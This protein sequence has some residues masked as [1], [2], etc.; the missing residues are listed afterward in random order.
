M[1]AE[2]NCSRCGE[3]KPPS[4]YRSVTGGSGKVYPRT[5]CRSCENVQTMKRRRR[6]SGSDLYAELRARFGLERE[7]WMARAACR[8]QGAERFFPAR[9]ES[10]ATTVR[11]MC[12]VCQVRAECLDYAERTNPHSGIWGGLSAKSRRRL[13]VEASS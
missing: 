12:D 11:E 6:S 5:Y 13:R 10:V 8:G 3:P 2:K 1:T 4:E 9:G 7:A